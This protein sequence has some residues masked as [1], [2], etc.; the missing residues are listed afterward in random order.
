MPDVKKEVCS[1]HNLYKATQVCRKNVR[2]KDSVAHFSNHSLQHVYKLRQT[3]INETYD[4]SPYSVFIIRE[5]KKRVITS[6]RFKDRVFQRSLCD[7]YLT[8]EITKGFIPNNYACQK[9]KGTDRARECLER[10]LKS[11]YRKAKTNGYVLKVDIHDY[12]GSTK[13]DIAKNAVLSRVRDNWACDEVK[14][15]IDS[16]E[17]EGDNSKGIGLG[18]QVSQLIQLAVLDDLDHYITETLGIELYV[19]YMDDFILIHEDKEYLHKCLNKIIR[20]LRKTNLEISPKK[21]HIFK[22]TQPIRFLGFSFKLWETGK[23]TKKL[24]TDNIKCERRKLIKQI[25]RVSKGLMTMA[26]FDECY[27]SWR[28]FA[29]K[30]DS[31]GRILKMDKFKNKLK[32]NYYETHSSKRT[33]YSSSSGSRASKECS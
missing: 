13:H 30:S 5:P 32:E 10:N 7:N 29:K 2:W 16:F 17:N 33:S 4:L 25:D 12:F 1:F 28:A 14:R 24:F 20:F 9:D 18:S 19:R 31:R 3:L 15:I 6:T 23:V 8:K 11:Y 27:Q 26:E 22:I 21:T